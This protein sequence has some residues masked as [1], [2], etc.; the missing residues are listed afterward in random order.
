MLGNLDRTKESTQE[1]RCFLICG[2]RFAR[3]VRWDSDQR[4]IGPSGEKLEDIRTEALA[5]R[6]AGEHGD[7]HIPGCVLRYQNPNLDSGFRGTSQKLG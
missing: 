3:C 7:N 1:V 2:I 6:R 5:L 4:Y